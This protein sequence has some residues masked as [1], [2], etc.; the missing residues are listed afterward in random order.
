MLDRKDIKKYNE[1]RLVCMVAA[2]CAFKPGIVSRRVGRLFVRN[3]HR[4]PKQ[5]RPFC[6]AK[7]RDGHAC[8]AHVLMRYDGT[9]AMR[10]RMHGG[11]STGAKTPEGK[12]RAIAAMQEGRQRWLAEMRSEKGGAV[13]LA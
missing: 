11:L 4:L 3:L 8:R 5:E 12:A 1:N 13:T 9:L 6:E 2:A 10:C 7:C